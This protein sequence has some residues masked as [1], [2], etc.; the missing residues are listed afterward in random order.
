MTGKGELTPGN[1][2]TLARLLGCPRAALY[3]PVGAPIP[4]QGRNR[5]RHPPH[6]VADRLAAILTLL[7]CD[8]EGFLR[9]LLAGDYSGLS[10]AVA[11]RLQEALTALRNNGRRH[12]L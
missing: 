11:E 3:E 12:R 10:V 9:F 5:R 7:D 8:F 6:A 4:P 1:S 2:A